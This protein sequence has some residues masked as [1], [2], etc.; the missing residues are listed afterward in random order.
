MATR[1]EVKLID[2]LDQSP[3]DE[4]VRFAL[5]GAD[6]EIDLSA[7]HAQALRENLADY[8]QAARKAGARVVKNA[9]A[10][11]RS[12]PNELRAIRDWARTHG[13]KVSN[14]G[15]I[16]APLIEAYRAEVG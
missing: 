6:Y 16:A 2:D 12:D 8:V 7:Y 9:T 4:T 10:H 11:R 5:D 3:A 15:R 13:H 14:R 1:T